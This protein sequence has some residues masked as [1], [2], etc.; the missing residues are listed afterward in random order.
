MLVFKEIY[1]SSSRDNL[2]ENPNGYYKFNSLEIVASPFTT[3]LTRQTYS[4]LEW[5]GDIGGLNDSD[6]I[7]A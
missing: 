3:I 7:L 1:P 4:I 5:L 2:I 6:Y